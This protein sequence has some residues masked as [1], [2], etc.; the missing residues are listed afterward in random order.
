MTCF[1]FL[2]SE[3]ISYSMFCILPVSLNKSFSGSRML[4]FLIQFPIEA[5]S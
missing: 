2:I 1:V 3:G 4:L 5:Y